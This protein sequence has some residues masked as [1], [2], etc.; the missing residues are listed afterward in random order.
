MI[1]TI[2]MLVLLLAVVAAVA[3]LAERLKIPSWSFQA[4]TPP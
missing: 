3:V 4:F 1:S 2:Q